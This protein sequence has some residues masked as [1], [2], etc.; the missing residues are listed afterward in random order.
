MYY[1]GNKKTEH[2]FRAFAADLKADD[3]A[4]VIFMYGAEDF[5]IE[6]AANE[7]INRYVSP[8]S[9]VLDYDKAD[10]EGRTTYDILSSAETMSMLSE[11]RVVWAKDFP[12]LIKKTGTGFTDSDLKMIERYTDSPNEGTILIFSSSSFRNNPKDRTEVKTDLCK[13]LLKKAKCYNFSQLDRSAFISFAEKR[14]RA[15]GKTIYPETLRYLADVTGY[16]NKESEYNLLSFDSDLKKIIAYSGAEVREED[17]DKTIYGDM[18]KYV[19]NFLDCLSSGKKSDAFEIFHN[20]LSA[21]TD[22][23]EVLS[24]I[25]NH[26]EFMTEV[27]E[28]SSEFSDIKRIAKTLGAHEFRVKKAMSAAMR[29]NVDELKSILCQLYDI[30]RDIKRG[31]IQGEVALELLIGRIN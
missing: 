8:S 19:F 14:V 16:F 27:K 26:F 30:D 1:E 29:M 3:I 10:E 11:K 17:I 23:F 6:W 13:L 15:S 12:P 20:M 9:R 22:V 4:K 18:D 7:I 24:L 2:A 21:G 28:L 31:D 5:L 25:V